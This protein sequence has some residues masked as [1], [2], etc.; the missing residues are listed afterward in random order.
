MENATF[1]KYGG[2]YDIRTDAVA[3][4]ASYAFV[5]STFFDVFSFPVVAGDPSLLKKDPQMIVLSEATAGK[6]FGKTSAVGKEVSCRLNNKYYKVA[7]VLKV[8]RKSHIQFDVLASWDSYKW[9]GIE[10][11]IW[12][13]SERMHVFIQLKK[14]NTLTVPTGQPCAMSG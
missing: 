6:L 5:D 1:I 9:A 4:E 11:E 2:T 12:S 8:P 14:G 3:L 7:A 10:D 13:F